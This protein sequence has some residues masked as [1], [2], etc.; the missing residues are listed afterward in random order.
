MFHSLKIK[1]PENFWTMF[2]AR[3]DTIL[4]IWWKFENLIAT[5]AKGLSSVRSLYLAELLLQ[6]THILINHGSWGKKRKWL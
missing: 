5:K 1:D 4:Y 6:N 3:Y 2:S